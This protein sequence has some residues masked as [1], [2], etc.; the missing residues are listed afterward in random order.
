GN[1]IYFYDIDSKKLINKIKIINSYLKQKNILISDDAKYF[2]YVA[3]EYFDDV[4][5]ILDINKDEDIKSLKGHSREI[6][7]L[8]LHPSGNY[9]ASGS[10]DNTIRIWDLNSGKTIKVLEGHNDNVNYISF[11]P[12]GRFLVSA[13]DDKSVIIWDLSTFSSEIDLYS[14]KYSLDKGI[15][16]YLIEEKSME[17]NKPGNLNDIKSIDEKYAEKYNN[18]YK[19]KLEEYNNKKK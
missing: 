12:D 7:C 5:K 2:Y 8:A 11:S 1:L 3:V 19:L 14:L 10:K 17:L 4:I 18:L 16:K 13:S 9:I 15:K 6:L